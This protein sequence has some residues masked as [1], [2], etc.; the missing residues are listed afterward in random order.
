M[1]QIEAPLLDFREGILQIPVLVGKGKRSTDLFEARRVLAL[2]QKPIPLQGGR[3]R[4]G[5]GI[6]ARGR[7]PGQ[8][9]PPGALI[10]REAV[11]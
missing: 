7:R 5:S 10:G 9:G 3:K 4:K 6:Q 11:G 8:E 1:E 2:S